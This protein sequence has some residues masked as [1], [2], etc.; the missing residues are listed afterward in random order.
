MAER[1]F[2]IDK[3]KNDP[4]AKIGFYWGES[5]ISKLLRGTGKSE[6]VEGFAINEFAI[7]GSS[8]YDAGGLVSS[9]QEI[10]SN[11][12]NSATTLMNTAFPDMFG[13]TGLSQRVVKNI[14]Q[15]KA[16]WSGTD[17]PTF[18]VSFMLIGT[19]ETSG[20]KVISDSKKMLKTVY[21]SDA[22]LLT[23]RAPLGYATEL[24]TLDKNYVAKGTVLVTI[25]QW[26]MAPNQIIKSVNI[27]YSKEQIRV[28]RGATEADD[29]FVPL[30][31]R[32][33]VQFEP[34]KLPTID[35]IYDYFQVDIPNE[36]FLEV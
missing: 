2:E 4:N 12:L 5:N 3:L 36:E 35:E 27:N 29:V 30:Y 1:K 13:G 31:A 6:S 18:N 28:S 26:F 34:Y 9:L 8:Q 33:D 25:G 24:K 16:R 22:G 7:G 10:A 32:V 23:I 17:K 20:Y 11:I 21:P 19:D 15:T 14:N